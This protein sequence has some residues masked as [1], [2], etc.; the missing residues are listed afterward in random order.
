MPN[1]ESR[2]VARGPGPGVHHD[3]VYESGHRRSA[4][5]AGGRRGNLPA[6]YARFVGRERQIRTVLR[7]LRAHRLVTVAGAPGIGKSRLA[8]RAAERL[9]GRYP[10]G[11]WLVDLA[12]LAD[13]ALVASAVCRTLHVRQE[14]R[15]P[16]DALL[17]ALRPSLSLLILDNG[18]HL[19][20]ACAALVASL[21]N[22]CPRLS[23]LVTSRRALGMTGEAVSRV[24]ALTLPAL[25]TR[26]EGASGRG[27]AA[28][29]MPAGSVRAVLVSEAGR[30][31]VERAK[32]ARPTFSLSPADAVAVAKV[33]HR[34]DGIPL[35]IELAA[36]RSATLWPDQLAERLQ[37]RFA[38]LSGGS[39]V[40]LPRHQTLRAMVDWSHDLLDAAEQM[41][42]RRLGV[43]AGGFTLEAAEAVA[44]E[45]A[46][47]ISALAGLVDASL[48]I[49]EEQAGGIRYRLLETLREYA[50]DRLRASGEEPSVRSRHQR[51]YC[52]L[53][54]QSERGFFGPAHRSWC[55][56]LEADLDNLRA[57]LAWTRAAPPTQRPAALGTALTMA[58]ALAY[59]WDARGHLREGQTWL[60]E[61]LAAAA[62][63]EEGDGER[64]ND[65]AGDDR[66][67]D[68][69]VARARTAL[70]YA[71]FT[72]GDAQEA[73]RLLAGARHWIDVTED[74]WYLCWSRVVLAAL[75]LFRGDRA[76]ASA[77][78]EALHTVATARNLDTWVSG[79]AFWRGEL[80][81]ADRDA[82][83]AERHG[84]RCLA[85]C[86]ASGN[87]WGL[88]Y[89][90][91][92]LGRIAAMQGD[93]DRAAAMHRQALEAR[94]HLDDRRGV[95]FS[96]AELG[97]ALSAGHRPADGVT[98]LA[99]ADALYAR[100][101]V[102]TVL[103]PGWQEA[104]ERAAATAQ[105]TLDPDAVERASRHGA[106]LSL[107]EAVEVALGTP[108]AHDAVEA[109]LAAA[110]SSLTERQREIVAQ[111]ADGRTNR[112]ISDALTLSVRTVDW[113]VSN[114][115][116]KL[117]LRSRAQL[118]RW[119][120]ER[121]NL[122]APPTP[123]RSGRSS[124]PT[125]ERVTTALP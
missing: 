43:F 19:A 10:D 58:A 40:V 65:A 73:E 2:G 5:D 44:G 56:R 122:D 41:L 110:P 95:I 27:E 67:S 52:D 97:L 12:A 108:A 71:H 36:A 11:I 80:A 116:A 83:A 111:V 39:P 87:V 62:L 124:A 94:Q 72:A 20:P 4:G 84:E 42:F 38:V 21:L 6:P 50:T 101:G 28:P 119:A 18:E 35:A 14:T 30:L 48:L 77:S 15:P 54:R 17:E 106:A 75:A 22:G 31:F 107:D 26:T 125:A 120:V 9:T 66:A 25:D 121:G 60:G 115:L 13:P 88:G 85:L 47:S 114:L 78:I 82:L 90:L 59:F 102:T 113:H 99:A 57:A 33:C 45:E 89:A 63:V 112:E 64:G 98:L 100:F 61:L 49:A 86:R 37:D 68:L 7:L 117:R 34:L 76:G 55:D 16:L 103:L 105:L 123:D 51:W 46:F 104:R 1:G 70:A 93:I 23:V 81:R 29:P 53:A 69:A 118:A 79:A 109:Q 92:A 3:G 91:A 74:A 32:T 8:I 96:L 24:P